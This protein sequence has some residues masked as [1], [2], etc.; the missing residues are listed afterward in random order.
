M[1]KKIKCYLP[2]L[3]LLLSAILYLLYIL[4][5]QPMERLYTQGV[6]HFL[7]QA[8]A[9][10]TSLF[11]F[12]LAE[13]TLYA[14]VVGAVFF[15]L[16]WVWQVVRG[17]WESA[18]N[19]A[20]KGLRCLWHLALYALSWFILFCGLNYNRPPVG[21]T[22]GYPQE[23][24]Y[25]AKDLCDLAD[26]MVGQTNAA[27]RQIRRTKE[28]KMN[29]VFTF[30]KTKQSVFRAYERL[31]RETGLKVGGRFPSVKPFTLSKLM[32]YSYIMGFF[33]PWTMESTINKDVPQFWIPA[34]MAHEQA[35]ARGYMREGDANYLAFRVAMCSDNEELRYSGLLHSLNYVLNA[36]YT[37]DPDFQKVMVQALDENVLQDF[38]ENSL[39]W[40]RFSSN[41]GE[42]SNKLNDS[43][44][45]ANR[46]EQ[47]VQSYGEVVDLL[48]AYHKNL[49]QQMQQ[50]EKGSVYIS[51]PKK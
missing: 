42:V 49:L 40:D 50:K 36:L 22:L 10:L 33:F 43:Y 20:L 17:P 29:P 24:L 6:Y 13:L 27:S 5:P 18:R 31:E 2:Y 4:F 23:A 41:W 19:K 46:Q 15:V 45:K 26:Y 1:R 28:G 16:R 39:Y 47:G 7:A 38:R 48:L 9:T 25:S 44:L 37:A 51:E 34:L 12:S 30:D 14:L 3:T 21:Q 35:H 32:S 8:V 11:P